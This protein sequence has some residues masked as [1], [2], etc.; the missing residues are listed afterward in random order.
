MRVGLVK[1]ASMGI[2]PNWRR[3]PLTNPSKNC[4]QQGLQCEAGSVS[5]ISRAKQR[6]RYA[7]EKTGVAD[8]HSTRGSVCPN[9][10]SA[11][12]CVISKIMWIIP[13]NEISYRVPNNY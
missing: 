7:E 11:C 12:A 6:K 2:K 9:V 13:G 8:H 3:S 1:V 5:S 10:C 4:L